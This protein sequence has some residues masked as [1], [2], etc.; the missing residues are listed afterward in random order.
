MAIELMETVGI[1]LNADKSFYFHFIPDALQHPPELAR[2][3]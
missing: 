3:P 2:M 1:E